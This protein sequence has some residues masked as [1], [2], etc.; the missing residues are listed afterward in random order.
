[1]KSPDLDPELAIVRDLLPVVPELH[2]DTFVDVVRS[3]REKLPRPDM[4]EIDG[5]SYRDSEIE[6]SVGTLGVRIISPDAPK[7]D[8]ACIYWIHGGGYF[9]GS[10]FESDARAMAWA[11]QLDAVIVMIDYSLAPESPYPG[12]LEDCYAGLHWTVANAAELGIDLNKLV[13]GGISAGGGLCAALA[14][15]CR[16]RGE[17]TPCYQVLVYP[18]IEDRGTTHSNQFDDAPIWYR[19]INALAWI[20]YLGRDH[21]ERDVP[22]TGAPARASAEQLV[23]LPPALITVGTV[24]P[25]CDEDITYAQTLLQAGVPT[26]LHVYPGAFHGFDLLMPHTRISQTCNRDIV[27]ALQRA[28]TPAG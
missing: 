10:A 16:D 21:L 11:D 28:L 27:E 18:M 17:I 9:L 1:M 24:D 25:F 26:E 15:L 6:T 2:I 7:S 22:I 14:I 4:P 3:N 5:I 23:G 13:I 8:R 20:A 12:A 19:T